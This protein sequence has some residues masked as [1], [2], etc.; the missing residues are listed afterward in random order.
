MVFE[1]IYGK[2]VD[3]ITYHQFGGFLSQLREVIPHIQYN[4]PIKEISNIEEYKGK[5][6]PEARGKLYLKGLQQRY[7][8]D[9]IIWEAD[10]RHARNA[11]DSILV[12]FQQNNEPIIK[13]S[14]KIF[15]GNK[16]IE[17]YKIKGKNIILKKF[18]PSGQIKELYQTDIKFLSQNM[19]WK[20]WIEFDEK[21]QVI[22]GSN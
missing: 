13:M 18:Y 12:L 9:T 21:G 16:L 20:T 5:Y 17:E 11:G 10:F 2:K 1:A 6:L 8:N 19:R 22:N 14:E 3:S 7:A 15:F 4:E